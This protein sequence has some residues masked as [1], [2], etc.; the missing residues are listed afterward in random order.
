MAGNEQK[1]AEFI[2]VSSPEERLSLVCRWAHRCYEGGQTVAVH[3]AT[4]QDAQR[5]DDVL[6]TFSEQSFIPHVR[7]GEAAEPVIEPVIIYCADEP[8]GEADV[9]IEAAGG[10]PDERFRQFAHLFDFA[11]LYDE[12]LTEASRR[13]YA[14]Y[15]E[16][17]YRMRYI[18]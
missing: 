3:L 17:G 1:I 7:F 4:E 2:R 11:E 14:A 18:K 12:A 6:W 5:L 10:G 9:L 16:A 8:I 13:R 15:K